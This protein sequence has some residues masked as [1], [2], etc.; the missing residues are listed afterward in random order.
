M[1]PDPDRPARRRLPPFA[2]AGALL[3]APALSALTGLGGFDWG[4]ADF[5]LAAL[6][7]GGAALAWDLAARGDARVRAAWGT[8]LLT[9]LVTVWGSLAVGLLGD[10]GDPANLL[11]AGVLAVALAGSALARLRPPGMARAMAATAGAQALAG[12]V[13]LAMGYGAEGLAALA[14]AAP[15]ALSGRLFQA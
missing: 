2:L 11:L 14:L 7:L 3:L 10:E 13:A 4:P 15:W 9:G 6:L 8:A 12:L 1:T 5:A